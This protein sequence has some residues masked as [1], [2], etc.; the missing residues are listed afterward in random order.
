MV[1]LWLLFLRIFGVMQIVRMGQQCRETLIGDI[2]IRT[3]IA[4]GLCLNLDLEERRDE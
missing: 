2:A 3:I 1:N 4:L